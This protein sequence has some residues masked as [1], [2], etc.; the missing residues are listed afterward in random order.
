MRV[1]ERGSYIT[2]SAEHNTNHVIIPAVEVPAYNSSDAVDVQYP[3]RL[4][5]VGH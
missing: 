1:N 3:R 4:R 2:Y 5:Y